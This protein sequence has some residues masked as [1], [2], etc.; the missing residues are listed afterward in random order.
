MQH[1]KEEKKAGKVINSL[2]RNARMTPDKAKA[3]VQT[4]KQD[5]P[6]KRPENNKVNDYAS[7]AAIIE[8]KKILSSS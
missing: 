5:E 2:V 3:A 4:L 6:K 8:R 1:K 7:F